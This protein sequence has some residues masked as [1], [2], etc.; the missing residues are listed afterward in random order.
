MDSQASNTEAYELILYIDVL[1]N[2]SFCLVLQDSLI[3]SSYIFHY[4]FPANCPFA[5]LKMQVH[6]SESLFRIDYQKRS[7]TVIALNGTWWIHF[8]LNFF[9]RLLVKFDFET[10]CF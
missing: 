6:A 10:L 5:F 2:V 9:T 4:P 1:K 7:F 3:F 8:L